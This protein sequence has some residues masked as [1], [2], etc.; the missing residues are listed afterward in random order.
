MNGDI[1]DVE[2]GRNPGNASWQMERFKGKTIAH[3]ST[4]S[5]KIYKEPRKPH[6]EPIRDA[7][8]IIFHFTDGT[9]A[10]FQACVG[11]L[12]EDFGNG[13]VPL[14]TIN[15]M[16]IT[17]YSQTPADKA[18]AE[19]RHQKIKAENEA[20]EAEARRKEARA[21]HHPDCLLE[22]DLAELCY[23]DLGDPFGPHEVIVRLKP[24]VLLS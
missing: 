2:C 17:E 8:F 1:E 22:H 6:D 20:A 7:P 12:Q 16:G 5:E 21:K 13:P 14:L 15:Y 23:V 4:G 19:L 24:D 9:H 3:Y 11:G 10:R 18:A